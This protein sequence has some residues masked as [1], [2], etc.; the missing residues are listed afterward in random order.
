VGPIAT[1]GG[2]FG[3]RGGQNMLEPAGYGSA[4]SFGPNT[5]NF[6]MIAKD[7]I[8]AGGAVRVRDGE[9]LQEFVSTCL[10]NIPA[11]DALGTSARSVVEKHR[12]ATERTLDALTPQPTIAKAA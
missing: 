6:R 8:D 2:S 10:M 11:A 9:T 7:L 1:V 4:V 12:G 5:K 3:D